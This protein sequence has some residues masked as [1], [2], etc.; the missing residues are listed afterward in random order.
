MEVEGGYDYDLVVI[1][2][3]SG[4]L[5]ASKEAAG[6]GKKVAVLDFVKPTPIG[7]SW[8]LG[9]TCVNVG[10]IPKKLMH[11]AALMGQNMK[12]A[13]SYGWQLQEQREHN[14]A[15]MVEGVQDHIG[16]LNWGYR[17]SLREKGVNYLNAYGSFVDAHTIKTVDKRGREKNIT[18][19]KI[20][21]AC[22]GRPT[23][24][25][26]PGAKEYGITSDDIFSL[27]QSPGDTV[28]VGA[29]Y[30]ALECAGFLRELGYNVTVLMRSIPLRGFDQQMAELIVED[31]TA[32]GVK[33]LR[34][35]IP[36]KIE[37]SGDAD[38][39]LVVGYQATGNQSDT[40]A[41][42]CNTVLLAIGRTADTH[43]M[44]LPAAGVHA[45]SN[46]KIKCVNEQTNVENV[47][48][49]G[50]VLYGRPEL[51]PVAI[52]AG[53]LLAQRLYG[54]STEQ[55]DYTNI[56]TT[57]FTPLEYGCIG[58]SEEAAIETY[59]ED[60]IEVYHTKYTPL[61][62]TVAHREGPCYAKLICARNEKERVV[63]F[64][65]TGPNAGEMTQGYAVGMRLGA[66]KHD[67]DMTVG[68]HPTNS[69][70]LVTLEVTKR[71]GLS[72]EKSA[73]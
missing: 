44:N 1:G 11:T 61:E 36:T 59:G 14:W 6:L 38:G 23:Y 27:Q 41:I 70:V 71:S 15:K 53:R 65:V 43:N 10:C 30:V 34:G 52:Q 62:W 67:F 12:D 3:G 19:D 73:C 32:H 56:A 66:T 37:K 72:V 50:D 57:I 54:G 5:A 4:G 18:A 64:H 20:L 13:T 7:T 42:A 49:I 40:G 31:M 29:S 8:G 69:E 39:K 48:A 24:P 47:Y 55:M 25:D 68:I 28:V 46:G 58:L 22:G 33:F 63:G 51:T 9:G 2:G 45:E 17:V 60:G 16:S 35:C 26:I 21:I